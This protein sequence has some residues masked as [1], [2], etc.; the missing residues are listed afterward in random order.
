MSVK[1]IPPQT[2]LL[3]RKT[4]VCR[5]IPNCL[6]FD[7]KHTLCVP[8]MYVLSENVKKIFF[9]FQRIFHFFPLILHGQVFFMYRSI[10]HLGSYERSNDSNPTG[11]KSCRAKIA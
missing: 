5:G 1:C 4:G 8:T 9:F 3:Y 11:T 10:E 7:P 6:I 2:S